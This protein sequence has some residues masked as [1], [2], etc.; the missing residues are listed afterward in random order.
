M[1][2]GS[3]AASLPSDDTPVTLARAGSA[4]IGV[5]F[6]AAP[7]S[8]GIIHASAT[9]SPD[10]GTVVFAGF[11]RNERR[12]GVPRLWIIPV[13]G[14]Q[15]TPLTPG[16]EVG[17]RFPCWSPDGSLI[18]FIEDF[19][20]SDGQEYPAVHL[21][22]AEGGEARIITGETDGV[23]DGSIAFA[24]DVGRIAFFSDK[25]IKTVSLSGGGTPGL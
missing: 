5:T 7:P 19:E 13:A 3:G 15:P 9:G 6:L 24:P 20:G 12:D 22:P 10:G 18:A 2:A 17:G 16:G 11:E 21:I 14:G 8:Y 4:R 25:A 1:N 23:S